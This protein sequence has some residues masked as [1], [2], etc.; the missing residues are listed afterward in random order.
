MCYI[1]IRTYIYIYVCVCVCVHVCMC[2]K[3]KEIYVITNRN[4]VFVKGYISIFY[5]FI[6]FSNFRFDFC[7]WETIT[8]ILVDSD[9]K[10][11]T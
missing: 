2:E 6:P 8:I 3:D 7:G 4:W 1:Y 11:Y 5:Y 9:L 10:G